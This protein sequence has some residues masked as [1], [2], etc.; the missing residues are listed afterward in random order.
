MKTFPNSKKRKTSRGI[1]KF[2]IST[3]IPKFLE[4]SVKTLFALFGNFCRKFWN[5]WILVR[6]RQICCSNRKRRL[7][8]TYFS[9]VANEGSSTSR[10]CSHNSWERLEV[11][12]SYFRQASWATRCSSAV[13][14]SMLLHS[15]NW[16]SRSDLNFS[17]SS[18]DMSLKKKGS[19]FH[20][21]S[22]CYAV[23]KVS[24]EKNLMKTASS[25]CWER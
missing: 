10:N 5:H 7:R 11:R 18:D 24:I 13:P 21:Y 16:C 22:N 9:F 15:A 12:S 23:V 2:H 25:C 19:G 14:R 17:G 1:H 6:N 20:I 4:I 3:P 8:I